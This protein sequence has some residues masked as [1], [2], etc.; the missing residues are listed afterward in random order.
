MNRAI[1]TVFDVGFAIVLVGASVAVLAGVPAPGTD[2]PPTVHSGG[3]V[4]LSGS[5]MTVQYPRED[6]PPA[7]VTGT[8]AGHVRDAAVARHAGVG[9]DYVAAVEREVGTRIKDTG[10]RTQ[11]VGAC[12]PRNEP[13]TPADT[14][15][16]GPAP[17]T[18]DPVDATAYRWNETD[19]G[20][21]RDCDPVVVVRR[22]SP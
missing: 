5:T 6:G 8:V 18:G 4:A 1:S 16:V 22:W 14:I 9:D 20:G 12:E 13:S 15:V 11:L 21:S 7:V 3:G 19:D 10:T 2:Q 17:P